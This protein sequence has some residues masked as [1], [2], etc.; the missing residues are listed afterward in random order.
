MPVTKTTRECYEV[1]EGK[2]CGE[3]ANITLHCWQ[4]TANVGTKHEGIYYCGEITIQSSFGTWGYIWTACSA[5]FKHFLTKI[6]FDYAFTKFMGTKLDRFDG[7]ASAREVLKSIIE[8]RCSNGMS[9]AEAREA[10]DAFDDVRSMAECGEHDFGTAMMD[11]ARSLGRD[12][13]MHDNFA[14]PCGWPKVTKYDAQAQGFWRQLWPLFIEA[15]KAETEQEQPAL[16][17]A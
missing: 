1:R 11:V 4:R 17:A 7:E 12:H 9:K 13:P 14:D 16:Q 2:P 5:P 15:L 6:E 8:E 3:W 10:W